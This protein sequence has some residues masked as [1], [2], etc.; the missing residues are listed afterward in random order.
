MSSSRVHIGRLIQLYMHDLCIG[1]RC[2]VTLKYFPNLYFTTPFDGQWVSQLVRSFTIERTGLRSASYYL[3]D[4]FDSGT[5]H[6]CFVHTLDALLTSFHGLAQL[7]A[8]WNRSRAIVE[9]RR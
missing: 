6:M 8:T 5:Y 2:R 9:T 1:A 7:D 3:L 4:S